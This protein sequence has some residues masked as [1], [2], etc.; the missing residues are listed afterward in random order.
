MSD[1]DEAYVRRKKRPQRS[2]LLA[3]LVAAQEP[4][5]PYVHLARQLTQLTDDGPCRIGR[6][7][8]L[9]Q[10]ACVCASRRA[11]WCTCGRRLAVARS[12]RTVRA[13]KGSGA[14]S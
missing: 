12:L 7:P 9:P 14:S 3:A 11:D 1:W 6:T 10:T 5:D 4:A 8:S 13:L 2:P